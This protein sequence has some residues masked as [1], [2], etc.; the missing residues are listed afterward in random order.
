[1]DGDLYTVRPRWGDDT[2]VMEVSQHKWVSWW[3]L[4]GE[5][6]YVINHIKAPL[7]KAIIGLGNRISW[8]GMLLA[9]IQV[10][11][12]ARRYPEPTKELTFLPHTHLLL[13]IEKR[14]FENEDNPGR[15]ALFRAMWRMFIVEYEHDPYY[16]V[17]IDWIVEQIVKGG[18]GIRPLIVK[19]KHW[20]E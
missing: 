10:V 15:E 8:L 18:W 5:R 7:E 14:F 12:I 13:D 2:S 17:R 6:Q 3:M 4:F 19:T 1:M 9:L 16:Q 20:K 11:R